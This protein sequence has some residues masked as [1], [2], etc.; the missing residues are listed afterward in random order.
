MSSGVHVISEVDPHSQL[1]KTIDRE[2][3][4][5]FLQC[6]MLTT[7]LEEVF[8]IGLKIYLLIS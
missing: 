2:K 1:E 6:S 5:L 4:S 8:K 3:V 7:I